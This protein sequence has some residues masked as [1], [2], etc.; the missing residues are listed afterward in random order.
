MTE[1][2]RRQL[3]ESIIDDILQLLKPQRQGGEPH[4]QTSS[5]TP[6]QLNRGL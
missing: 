4:V 6:E 3:I 2:E 5:G 1:T